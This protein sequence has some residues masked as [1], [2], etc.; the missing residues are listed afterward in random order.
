MVR[1]ASSKKLTHLKI[2]E[3][4]SRRKLTRSKCFLAF[5]NPIATIP[6]AIRTEPQTMVPGM[7]IKE[8]KS[9]LQKERNFFFLAKSEMR[10]NKAHA[11]INCS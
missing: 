1:I 6:Y 11:K 4:V 7:V 3:Y 10:R 9:F 8:L 2:K 5:L